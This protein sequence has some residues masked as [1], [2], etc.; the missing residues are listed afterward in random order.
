MNPAAQNAY[1]D[2][3]LRLK[4]PLPWVFGIMISIGI[5]L[6]GML[7][8]TSGFLFGIF[9]WL[10]PIAL[11]IISSPIL[12]QY[13][14]DR[15]RMNAWRWILPLSVLICGL[16]CLIIIGIKNQFFSDLFDIPSY[17]ILVVRLWMLFVFSGWLQ[18]VVVCI[19]D[20]TCLETSKVQS[21]WWMRNSAPFDPT[22]L[23]NHLN[24]LAKK[25]VY[26]AGAT[27]EDIVMFAGFYR[28]WLSMTMKPL[29]SLEEE[30]KLL[31]I[32]AK[33]ESARMEGEFNVE[34]FWAP[35]PAEWKLPPFSL[36]SFAALMISRGS[37]RLALTARLEQ[38]NLHLSIRGKLP[39]QFKEHS[40]YKSITGNLVQI[41]GL[42]CK[43][44][45]Q[46]DGTISIILPEVG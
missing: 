15:S 32:F 24:Y 16:L 26:D 8:K 21:A 9:M 33:V 17:W 13:R 5:A 14:V 23:A 41:F 45:V 35:G 29:V 28:K 42:E 44:D 12:W 1:K 30:R 43:P 27:I 25:I 36:F 2:F 3:Q 20:Q 6:N 46:P 39:P 19:E 38:R 22:L 11:I 18:T 37:K 31:E 40:L 34:W 10:P 7:V 4:S